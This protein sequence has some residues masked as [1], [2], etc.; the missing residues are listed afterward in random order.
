MPAQDPGE[1]PTEAAPQTEHALP[2]VGE[3][4]RSG[5]KLRLDD[6]IAGGLGGTGHSGQELSQEIVVCGFASSS[7]QN[8]QG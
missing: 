6:F 7:S 3:E 1:V 4:V 5:L 8:R 2:A